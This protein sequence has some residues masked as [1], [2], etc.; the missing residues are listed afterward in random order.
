[1]SNRTKTRKRLLRV[2][3]SYAVT[4]GLVWLAIIGAE[5]DIYWLYI[6]ALIGAGCMIVY[7]FATTKSGPVSLEPYQDQQILVDRNKI[8]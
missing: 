4:A 6:P 1:M 2:V 8:D 7:I 3:L 5:Q